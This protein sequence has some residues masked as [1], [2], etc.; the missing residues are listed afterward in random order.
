MVECR[1]ILSK[2][3][4][5]IPFLPYRRACWAACAWERPIFSITEK[6]WRTSSRVWVQTASIKSQKGGCSDRL[7]TRAADL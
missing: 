1:E 3:K 2:D 4:R 7:A 5:Y 6:C